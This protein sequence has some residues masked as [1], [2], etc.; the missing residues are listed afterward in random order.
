MYIHS[1]LY[2]LYHGGR[3]KL[4]ITIYK[5]AACAS[6]KLEKLHNVACFIQTETCTALI[7]LGGHFKDTSDFSAHFTIPATALYYSIIIYC[8]DVSEIDFYRMLSDAFIFFTTLASV[9]FHCVRPAIQP[10]SRTSST[11]TTTATTGSLV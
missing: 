5:V 10:R 4:Q 2:R 11:A 7:L 9:V 3:C 6:S 8:L 1:G